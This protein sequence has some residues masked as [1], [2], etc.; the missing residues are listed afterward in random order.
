MLKIMSAGQVQIA[1]FYIDGKRTGVRTGRRIDNT[2]TLL[3]FFLD[4]RPV[5]IGTEIAK[6]GYVTTS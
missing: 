4:P 3:P 1:R 6:Q 5:S 2:F